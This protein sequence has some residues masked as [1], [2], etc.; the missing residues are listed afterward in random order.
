MAVGDSGK[1]DRLVD[2]TSLSSGECFNEAPEADDSM[3]ELV[4]CSGDWELRVLNSFD[5]AETRT[6]PRRGPYSRSWRT[7]TATGSTTSSATP[8]ESPGN[9]R[10]GRSPVLI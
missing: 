10:T 3:V 4:D 2:F 7:R 9:Q 1:L 8:A 5:F 6:L